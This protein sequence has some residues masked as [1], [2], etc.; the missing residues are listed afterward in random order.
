MELVMWKNE[1][2]YKIPVGQN[3]ITLH[4]FGT[5]VIIDISG[6]PPNEKKLWRGLMKYGNITMTIS[7]WWANLLYCGEPAQERVVGGPSENVWY[8]LEKMSLVGHTSQEK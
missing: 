2:G 5:N 7:N 4:V 6:M 8:L 3:Q 1:G